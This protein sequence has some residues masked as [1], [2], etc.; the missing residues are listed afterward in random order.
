MA[1]GVHVAALVLLLVSCDMN[2]SSNSGKEGADT[3]E[4][5]SYSLRIE[6]LEDRVAI[7]EEVEIRVMV[8]DSDAD[9]ESDPIA[10]TLAYQ[11]G[12]EEH[13]EIGTVDTEN[14]AA[15]FTYMWSAIAS[16]CHLWASTPGLEEDM[17]SEHFNIV[18]GFMDIAFGGEAPRDLQA[19]M[20]FNLTLSI[21]GGGEPLTND[22][23]IFLEA[24]HLN[25]FGAVVPE[26]TVM[27]N[28]LAEFTHLYYSGTTLAD[29]RV[30]VYTAG[31]TR[32]GT[33]VLAGGIEEAT[34]QHEI[35]AA[36]FNVAAD[37]SDPRLN[38]TI[39]GE[40]V[41]NETFAYAISHYG[42]NGREMM[43]SGISA[44]MG[45]TGHS[46]TSL[47]KKCFQGSVLEI[48]FA[49]RVHK[50]NMSSI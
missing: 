10:I 46:R 11:C 22:T 30:R 1:F 50:V 48:L 27:S 49:G 18:A 21:M 19:Q 45:T 39:D 43:C 8:E 35:T 20:T 13:T 12:E 40:G 28:G 26:A 47:D 6:G 36:V 17:A 23:K 44:P 25:Q 5:D 15:N 2:N 41:N 37:G 4:G 29:V 3:S 9:S 7:D 34:P 16:D 14:G 32:V 38:V 24:E 31:H 33:L 42:E